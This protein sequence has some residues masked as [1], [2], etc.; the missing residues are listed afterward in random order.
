MTLDSN[1]RITRERL[2]FL[3]ERQVHHPTLWG[4]EDMQSQL[5]DTHQMQRR[6]FPAGSETTATSE[7]HLQQTFPLEGSTRSTAVLILR[8]ISPPSIVSIKLSR[9]SSTRNCFSIERFSIFLMRLFWRARNRREGRRERFSI[10]SISF[11]RINTLLRRIIAHP[12]IL[13]LWRYRFVTGPSMSKPSMW[14]IFSRSSRMWVVLKRPS[15]LSLVNS[16][17]PQRR[18]ETMLTPHPPLTPLS[19]MANTCAEA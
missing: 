2:P 5:V 15:T 14:C 10:R 3:C 13:T 12:R 1:E 11:Y 6:D 8:E 4:A 17:P 7:V 16:F 9:R 19:H 18:F